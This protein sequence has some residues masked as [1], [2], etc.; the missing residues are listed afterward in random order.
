[1]TTRATGTYTTK[2]WNENPYHQQEGSASLTRASVEN[3]F[4]GDLE[5]EGVL[6]YLLAYGEGGSA[7]YVGLQRFEGSIGDRK[8]TF[9]ARI[10][11]V[12]TSAA[13]ERWTLV[14]GTGTG[15]FAG[16]SGTGSVK[17]LDE[18]TAEY[19]VEYRL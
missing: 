17:S 6:E 4:S 15:D 14:E 5:G 2:S 7:T 18:K 10:E 1:M 11:G 19:T 16:I 3:T 9:V 8:G 13:D 12:F